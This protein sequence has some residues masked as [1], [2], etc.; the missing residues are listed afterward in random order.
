MR[1]KN[2]QREEVSGRVVVSFRGA[3]DDP[4]VPVKSTSRVLCSRQNPTVAFSL[5]V[6]DET[7]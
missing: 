2:G 1:C 7:G 6:K 5:R 3:P 4:I